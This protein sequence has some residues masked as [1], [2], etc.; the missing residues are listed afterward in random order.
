MRRALLVGIDDYEL[1]RLTGCVND[2]TSMRDL[3]ARNEDEGPNF[4]CK[5]LTAP[6]DYITKSFL[7]E[8]IEV[9]FGNQADVALFYFA[10]HGTYDNLDGYLVTQDVGKYDE[11]VRMRDIL[12]LANQA[13]SI[14]EIVIIL[15]CC[16]SG[17]FG[18]VAE[19]DN[20]NALIR[21]G[22]SILTASRPT[23]EAAETG[24]SGVFTSLVRNA[25]N[26][27]AAD[28]CGNVTV[29]AV[30]A[31]VDQILGAWDQRP[32]F[33][34]HV[35]KLIPL[36]KCKP[37][38]ELSVLRQL[39]KYFAH[40]GYDF[41]LDPSYEPTAEPRDEEHEK[42]FSYLQKYRDARLLVPVDEMHLYYAA[43]NGKSCKLTPIGQYYWDL[44]E[45]GKI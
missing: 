2:A 15:D 20:S 42:I 7:R 5:L 28:V 39:P 30:Y 10:G 4:D 17:I 26:G 36:R 43:M 29:A 11:G 23:Q 8:Q 40:P 33:K 25:L 1:G 9:L 12:L 27:G 14:K 22:V 13:K 34:S 44:V 6:N 3:L 35:S 45:R 41:K 18:N 32:L 19:F 38:I 16:H 24:G 37:Q 31:F 21:E